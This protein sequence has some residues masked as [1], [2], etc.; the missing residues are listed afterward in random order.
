VVSDAAAIRLDPALAESLHRLRESWWQRLRSWLR[1]PS[2]RPVDVLARLRD[3]AVAVP[4]LTVVRAYGEV[5]TGMVAIVDLDRVRAHPNV[6]S[7]KAA[8]P[9]GVQLSRSVGAAAA[10]PAALRTARPQGPALNGAGVIVG[11]V[12]DGGDFAHANFRAAD[13][14]SRIAFLWDQ[15]AGRKDPLSP[16][17]FLY[18]R[19]LSRSALNNALAKS[20]PYA[21]AGY[22]P[23]PDAHGTHVM[24]IAAGNGRG[25]GA[26]GVAPGA[27]L[28]FVQLGTPDY[29]EGES[30]GNSRR[31]L[32]AVEYIFLRARALGR[33]A[34]VNVSIE[35]NGGPHDG[36]TLVEQGFE[37]LLAAD[38]RAIV[39]AAGNMG[40]AGAHASGTLSPDVPRTLGWRIHS[41]DTSDNE[42]EIWYT[43]AADVAVTVTA[44]TGQVLGPVRPGAPSEL[45][46]KN[47]VAVRAVSVRNDPSNGDHQVNVFLRRSAPKG[48]WRVQ[49]SSDGP[50]LFHAWIERDDFGRFQQSTFIDADREVATTLGTLGCGRA[51]IVV[52]ATDPDQPAFPVAPFS[53]RG[54]TRTGGQKPDLAAPG[55]QIRAAKARGAGTLTLSGTSMAAPHVTGAVALMFQAALPRQL[56]IVTLRAALLETATPAG[57]GWTA[58]GGHGRVDAAAAVA[59][60]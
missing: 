38:G 31:L 34:V 28:I 12:D 19:E 36:S 13:G 39:V 24:D 20:D 50:A 7:L 44:P 32:E 59:R 53:A 54:P 48:E 23:K 5:V 14:T 17:E 15:G 8:R 56:P 27:D 6:L 29:A 2:R 35:M 37:H 16:P 4:G 40:D 45:L 42:L 33:P 1:I 11:I 21:A 30:L 51:A 25:T 22:Q 52:A 47:K 46:I 10:T 58:D 9:V 3:P 55:N 43:G 57:S 26:P 41:A 49:L 18:G 60:V